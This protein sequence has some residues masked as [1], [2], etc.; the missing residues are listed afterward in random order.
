MLVAGSIL[1]PL[2]KYIMKTF[3][4]KCIRFLMFEFDFSNIMVSISLDEMSIVS[5]YF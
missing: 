4:F 3:F 1:T 2:G 5:F